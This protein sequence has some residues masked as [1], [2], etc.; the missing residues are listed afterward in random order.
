MMMIVVVV[1]AALDAG[2]PAGVGETLGE[3][4]GAHLADTLER[5]SMV[6]SR[7]AASQQAA[8]TP[9]TYSETEA[10]VTVNEM[11]CMH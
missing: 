6:R 7:R 9:S 10:S 3:G 2:L 4:L 5:V 11:W 1:I 8:F